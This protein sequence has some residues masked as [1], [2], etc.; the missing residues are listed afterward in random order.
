MKFKWI[1]VVFGLMVS[2]LLVFAPAPA[3][4]V[5][6]ADGNGTP[7]AC[8]AMAGNPDADDDGQSGTVVT[9][10][11]DTGDVITRICIRSAQN[12]FLISGAGSC[13]N[14]QGSSDPGQSGHS[15]CITSNGAYGINNCYTV[16]GIGTDTVTVTRGASPPC[17]DISHVDFEVDEGDPPTLVIE[18]ECEPDANADETFTFDITAPGSAEGEQNNLALDCG[19][20]SDE[21]ELEAGVDYSVTEDMPLPLGWT[22]D[23]VGCSEVS[24]SDIPNGVTFEPESGDEVVCTFT[25]VFVQP[26]NP[27]LRIDKVCLPPEVANADA[28]FSFDVTPNGSV[29]DPDVD[30]GDSSAIINLVAATPY[31]VVE[32]GL[33][34]ADWSLTSAGCTGVTDAAVANGRSFTPDADDVIVCTF[35]NTLEEEDPGSIRIE[36]D[37]DADGDFSFDDSFGCNIPDLEDGEGFTC[38]DLPA[39]LY[40]ISEDVPADW[41]LVDIEC[42]GD[43]DSVIDIDDDL[44]FEGADDFDGGDDTVLIQ[45]AAAENI[46]CTFFNEEEVTPQDE[47]DEEDE[48]DEDD[49]GPTVIVQAPPVSPP[50]AQVQGVTTA[51]APAPVVRIEEVRGLPSAGEGSLPAGQSSDWRM[52]AGLVLIAVSLAALTL[53]FKERS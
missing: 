43:D 6:F 45:L 9:I 32:D 31:T 10:E 24:E 33:E 7:S 46:V 41:D 39:G 11:A 52:P 25:N 26:Q 42:T 8:S 37:A 53:R 3:P 17:H 48:Q 47:Q 1:L 44:T 50:V 12:T 14:V 2:G 34:S 28:T 15:P 30:C 38:D 16:S 22:L 23:D 21:I 35:T 40:A 36:K 13:A 51:P 29:A 5:A 4:Q 18:K 27:T 49:E 20:E 19:E